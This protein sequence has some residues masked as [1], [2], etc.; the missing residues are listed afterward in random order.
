[1]IKLTSEGVANPDRA[2]TG[3]LPRAMLNQLL[4]LFEKHGLDYDTHEGDSIYTI[5]FNVAGFA[6]E[7]VKINLE[8]N[9]LSITADRDKCPIEDGKCYRHKMRKHEKR[10][11]LVTLP[12]VLNLG[13][14]EP[15]YRDGILSFNFPKVWLNK[16][17]G[18]VAVQ[19]P[20]EEGGKISDEDGY[21]ERSRESVWRPGDKSAMGGS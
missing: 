1:M 15:I 20:T 11:Q 7:D 9:V 12:K 4:G 2:F 14:L 16:H 6:S 13:K 18:P 10:Q 5:G 21:N 19:E 17:R 3:W 8:G